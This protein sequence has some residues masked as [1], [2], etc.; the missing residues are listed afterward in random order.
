M[1]GLYSVPSAIAIYIVQSL[2]AALTCLVF[3]HLGTKMFDEKVGLLAAVALALYPPAVF[4]SAMRVE[5]VVFIV[6]LLAWVIYCFLKISETDDYTLPI[7]CGLLIGVTALV[8]PTVLSFLVLSFGWLWIYSR[9][10]RRSTAKRLGIMGVATVLSIL[11]WT[12]RNYAV[13]GTFVPIKSAFGLNLLEGN[14][15]YGDG[16]MQYTKGFF[17]VEERE[18]IHRRP[19]TPEKLRRKE[20][21]S[22][23]EREQKRRMNEV[24]ADKLMFRKAVEFITA[25]PEKFLLFTMRR[26]FAFWSPVNPY[27]TTSYD[28]LRG[29][30][31]GVPLILGLAGIFMARHKWRETSLLVLLFISYPLSYYVTHISMYRYRYPVEPFLVLLSCYALIESMRKLRTKIYGVSRASPS[32]LTKAIN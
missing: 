5:P 15:P 23:A 12:I 28:R 19:E 30:V 7:V 17:S 26:I 1:F 2:F 18:K 13:F 16:V 29:L 25:E 8:E 6:F 22:E 9:T 20:I 11:P 21:L 24:E 32:V 10:S 31:Y 27:R 14:N 4:F 3:Y